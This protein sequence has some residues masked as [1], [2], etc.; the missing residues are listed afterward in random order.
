MVK[1]AS[2]KL[3][4]IF[5]GGYFKSGTSLLRAMLAQHSAIAAGLES[6][7]FDLDW[8]GPR[9]KKF[10]DHID[11]LR[12]FYDMDEESIAK[13]ISESVTALDFLDRFMMA[14]AFKEGKKRWAEKTPGN[15]L[16]LDRIYN[17]F[18]NAKVIHIIRDPK[19]VLASHRQAQKWDSVQVFVEKWCRF[20]GTNL[21]LQNELTP[22]PENY[23]T[24]RYEN[25]IINTVT[26]MHRV[27]NFLEEEWE[28]SV[29]HFSGKDDEYEKVLALTGKAS[30]TLDRLRKPLGRD[31]I[32]IW[33]SIL[34]EEEITA[35][36][37]GIREN[38]LLPLF[39]KIEEDTESLLDKSKPY[40]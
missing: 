10:H 12:K 38:G 21:K 7:W 16:Y 34:P 2:K 32:G 25:L 37:D 6:Y 5:I 28:D 30:T 29:A 13:L 19:D 33:K 15:I 20:F 24:I 9:E 26:T 40:P 4:P 22:G 11:R 31:R 14:Y 27:V 1:M 3:P 36:R 17:E 35:V 8:D 23:I 39:I 18:P